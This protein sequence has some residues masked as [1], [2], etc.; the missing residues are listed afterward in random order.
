[1]NSGFFQENLT[2]IAYF[3]NESDAQI[4]AVAQ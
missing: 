4:L 2:R 1:V 3:P